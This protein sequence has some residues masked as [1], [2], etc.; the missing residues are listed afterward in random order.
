MVIG[1]ASVILFNV[2]DTFW[3]GQLGDAELAAMSYT[4]PIV[5]VIMSLTMGLGI[6]TTSVVARAI[7]KGNREA[8]RRLTTDA[9][10][11]G[12]VVVLAF[13]TTGISTIG[14]LFAALGADDDT[15]TLIRQYMVPWYLGIGLIV[16]PMLGN[17]AIRSTGDTKTPSLIMMIAGFV[18]MALDPLLIFGA[19]PIPAMR[20]QGAAIATVVSY[21]TTAVA[22]IYLLGPKKLDLLD[23]TRR[24]LASRWDSWKQI[25]SI[26]LPAAAANILVPLSAAILTRII[27]GYGEYAVAGYGVSTRIESFT[28]VGIGA[29]SSALSPFVG[30]NYGAA[31]YARIREA[32]RFALKASLIFGVG[33]ALLLALT[34]GLISSA[35]SDSPEVHDVAVSYMRIVPVGYGALG[36]CM[37]VSTALNA[38]NRPLPSSGL[39]AMRLFVFAIPLAYLG[40]SYLDEPGVFA[41]V[42]LGNLAMG[43]I[44]WI[45]GRSMF[46]TEALEEQASHP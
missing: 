34:G 29:L 2:V 3:V 19:G 12:M 10:I 28:M 20:L 4:F 22:A 5:S 13:A 30:Q 23:R 43:I 35:F 46:D 42:A 1:I 44:A 36:V 14:P 18:N 39:I 17:S 40:S 6:G 7:G 31:N 26:G 15:V 8:V 25:V 21:G 27:S 45:L 24:S 37:L 11:L 33:F 16:I 32:V 9:L 41:G 38:I